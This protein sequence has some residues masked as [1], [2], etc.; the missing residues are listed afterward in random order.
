MQEVSNAKI[1]SNVRE[2]KQNERKLRIYLVGVE[3]DGGAHY[4][5]EKA[6][7]LLEKHNSSEMLH[8]CPEELVDYLE[9]RIL[10]LHFGR[11]ASL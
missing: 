2:V 9:Q 11:P 1:V 8:L 4:I 3:E 6:E 7:G 10:C 5:L